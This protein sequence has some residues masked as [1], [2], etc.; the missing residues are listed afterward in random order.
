MIK[1]WPPTVYLEPFYKAA[2]NLHVTTSLS[3][4]KKQQK[5]NKTKK[6]KKKKKNPKC[7]PLS[8]EHSLKFETNVW[9]SWKSQP[10]RSQAI[11]L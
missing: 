10:Q 1:F 9:K 5:K 3:K 8:P 6:Y 7:F 11:R 4:K 2:T